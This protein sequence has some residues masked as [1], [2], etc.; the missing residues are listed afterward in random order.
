VVPT[1]RSAQ[2]WRGDLL[3]LD[4]VGARRILLCL[5]VCCMIT[6]LFRCLYGQEGERRFDAHL[7]RVKDLWRIDPVVHV[8]LRVAR[9]GLLR[10]LY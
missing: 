6:L 4:V 2:C 7:R 5:L 3:Q 8:G 1:H 10:R 9:N